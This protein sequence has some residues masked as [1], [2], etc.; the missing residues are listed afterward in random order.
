LREHFSSKGRTAL[1]SFIIIDPQNAAE[2]TY[3]LDTP[4]QEET[5]RAA[6]AQAGVR[7]TAVWF[8]DPDC[9][10]SYESTSC[11]LFATWHGGER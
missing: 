7:Y 8:G 2:T 11:K 9:T 10:D 5:A 4:E 3:R 6:L 1:V